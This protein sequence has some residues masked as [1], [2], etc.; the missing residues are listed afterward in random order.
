MSLDHH[1]NRLRNTSCW[2]HW[3]LDIIVSYFWI[4]YIDT[5]SVY[6]QI[7]T[8]SAAV[9]WGGW[10][11]AVPHTYLIKVPLIAILYDLNGCRNSFLSVS[12]AN[13]PEELHCMWNDSILPWTYLIWF[14]WSYT[15][16]HQSKM[17]CCA[18]FMSQAYAHHLA[19]RF[20]KKNNNFD[21]LVHLI[22]IKP[23]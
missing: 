10:V 2:R 16:I 3:I 14:V 21:F 18:W 8:S 4:P 17:G 19:C 5:E 13:R 7:K 20:V 6:I 9:P 1:G 15:L 23:H 12:S 11:S 22:L